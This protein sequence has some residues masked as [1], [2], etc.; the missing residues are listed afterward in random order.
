MAFPAFQKLGAKLVT[1]SWLSD[2]G[3]GGDGLPL[4]VM[5]ARLF[6]ND[7]HRATLPNL[8]ASRFS[9]LYSSDH[10]AGTGY[11]GRADFDDIEGV[12]TDSG[13]AIHSHANQRETPHPVYDPV[14]N[15]VNV[16]VHDNTST[17]TNANQATR[18]LT[19]TDL[20]TLTDRG[21]AMTYGQHTGYAQVWYD[22]GFKAVHV[23]VGG[24]HFLSGYSTS[25]NGT[26]WTLQRL[27][28]PQANH[29]L[30]VNNL[31]G[32]D[33][34]VFRWD[35][36]TWMLSNIQVR[37]RIHTSRARGMSVCE[38][39][40][41]TFRPIGNVYYPLI[42]P[43]AI[44]ESDYRFDNHNS[45]VE[46][47]G[48]LYLLYDARTRSGVGAIHVAKATGVSATPFSFRHSV[49]S[50]GEL[51]RGETMA[52]PLDWNAVTTDLPAAVT[53][54]VAAGS[55]TSTHQ[56]GT[57]YRLSGTSSPDLWLH[58]VDTFN[59][60]TNETLEFELQ[61]FNYTGTGNGELRLGF[62]AG[63]TTLTEHAHLEWVET[64]RGGGSIRYS[65]TKYPNPLAAW[66]LPYFDGTAA[67]PKAWARTRPLTLS[68]RLSGH[69]TRISLLVDG[70]VT[71][72][73][74]LVYDG[75][76]FTQ[77]VRPFVRYTNGSQ[78]FFSRFLVRTYN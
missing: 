32:A 43:G 72:S 10:S 71:V 64:A 74:D 50:D 21:E 11:I 14:N 76:T 28:F 65:T 58:A 36:K 17:G 70:H 9:V 8:P 46:V 29:V 67:E 56:N 2:A 23:M 26:A 42:C 34:F 35:N 24:E 15:R 19:T 40:P 54:V 51:Q 22:N 75:M 38:I 33:P 63:T 69:G 60:L 78:L 39:D 12:W 61:G 47:D 5:F 44:T 77:A 1:P 73:R 45:I 59:P 6:D 66:T 13:A 52:A 48:S 27:I 16:Y 49:R 30:N 41:T 53:K 3:N 68:L 25:A 20:A 31:F 62:N 55:D 37:P 57:G 7:A 18:L 4:Q